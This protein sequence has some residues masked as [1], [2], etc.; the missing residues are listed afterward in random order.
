MAT[1]EWRRSQWA[2]VAH[3]VV[4]GDIL[5]LCGEL[6]EHQLTPVNPEAV[7]AMACESCAAITRALAS[8]LE[9]L[10]EVVRPRRSDFPETRFSDD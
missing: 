9:G 3:A 1:V 7:P 4:D 6:A 5:T 8:S 10:R 2:T